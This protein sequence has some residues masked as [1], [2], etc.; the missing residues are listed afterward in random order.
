M[1]EEIAFSIKNCELRMM[2]RDGIFNFL[3]MTSCDLEMTKDV[4]CTV[5][6]W[7]FPLFLL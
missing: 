7:I 3:E 6:L 2:V 1:M 4:N 5:L